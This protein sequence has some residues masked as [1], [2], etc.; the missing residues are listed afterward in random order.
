MGYIYIYI[1]RD[2]GKDNGNY[3]VGFRVTGPGFLV[4]LR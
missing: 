3:H 4:P 1:Y 2:T